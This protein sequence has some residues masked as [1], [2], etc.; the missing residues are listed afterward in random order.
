MGK[1]VKGKSLIQGN[2]TDLSWKESGN[3]AMDNHWGISKFRVH[4]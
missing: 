1:K 4:A 3:T 2:V